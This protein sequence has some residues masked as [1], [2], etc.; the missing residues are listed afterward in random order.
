MKMIQMMKVLLG[1]PQP[2]KGGLPTKGS[3]NHH[4]S[5]KTIE[6]QESSMNTLPEE[7]L[8]DL[9]ELQKE[10]EDSKHG[11]GGN[12]HRFGDHSSPGDCVA[13]QK[14]KQKP[15]E[16]HFHDSSD[17][18]QPMMMKDLGEPL[19]DI[20]LSNNGSGGGPPGAQSSSSLS[21]SRQPQQDDGQQETTCRSSSPSPQQEK[22]DPD[23]P[24][25]TMYE[26]EEEEPEPEERLNQMQNWLHKK[27]MTINWGSGRNLVSSDASANASIRSSGFWGSNRGG[28]GGKDEIN[29]DSERTVFG[30]K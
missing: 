30:S 23:D 4:D 26:E 5:V 3:N 27:G 16:D 1:L 28:S 17:H 20:D 12:L 25:H 10:G 22:Y 13:Q 9:P 15:K 21:S 6:F 18:S 8:P 14:E 29:K 2:K 24:F 19:L 7:D 11:G